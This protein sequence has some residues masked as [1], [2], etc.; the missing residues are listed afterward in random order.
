MRIMP[1]PALAGRSCNGRI[2]FAP[3]PKRQ[4]PVSLSFY[5]HRN[6]IFSPHLLWVLG[7]KTRRMSHDFPTPPHRKKP[8]FF[9][10]HQKSRLPYSQKNARFFCV[11]DK[12]KSGMGE[13]PGFF[14]NGPTQFAV[15]PL[16]GVAPP[17]ACPRRLL[18]EAEL[19]TDKYLLDRFPEI[20][21]K[22][23]M[24]RFMFEPDRGADASGPSRIGRSSK[25]WARAWATTGTLVERDE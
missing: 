21:Q 11:Q 6:R 18:S 12:K 9:P 16:G 2:L 25:M 15:P 14:P 3:T 4:N 7:S 13:K 8:G 22:D 1:V 10:N 24:F 20:C 23:H 5:L 19:Q 17:K